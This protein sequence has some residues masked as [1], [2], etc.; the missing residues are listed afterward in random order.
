M[1]DAARVTDDTVHKG[2]I[3]TGSRNVTIN[4]L[5]AVRLND[6]HVCPAH[7]KGAV[8]KG[9]ATV[10]INGRAA[11]RKGDTLLCSAGG[12]GGD[13]ELK[14]K[15]ELFKKKDDVKWDEWDNDRWNKWKD[16]KWG[17]DREEA[18]AKKKA[19]E[20][21]TDAPEEKKRPTVK[22]SASR[23]WAGSDPK[24][25]PLFHREGRL[26]EVSAG[27]A[28]WSV[29]SG[30]S[31]TAG[32]SIKDLKASATLLEVNGSATA[33]EVKSAEAD[34]LV[35]DVQ[36]EA[37][38]LTA[39][40][41]GKLGADVDIA[42]GKATVEAGGEIGASLVEGKVTSKWKPIPIPFTGL[43]IGVESEVSG[44][45]VTAKLEGKASLKIDEKGAKLKF[46]A[47]IGAFLAGLGFDFTINITRSK[48]KKPPP[49]KPGPDKISKG[50]PTVIIG[51]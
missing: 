7:T 8:S 15:L 20:E 25:K 31:L 10:V 41:S 49:P 5:P 26:G 47:G 32:R 35:A 3:A 36:A 44:S 1:P 33:F 16:R 2:K 40:A 11:A 48:P 9:S 28:S 27:K 4:S 42:A 34:L 51:G 37:A 43:E 29:K 50:S 39:N 24:A 45:L 38:V 21:G 30:A 46:G 12:G 22:L 19:Q 13:G 14:A 6:Q 18:E 17:A 23:Q